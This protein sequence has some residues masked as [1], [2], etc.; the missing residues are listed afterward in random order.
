MLATGVIQASFHSL[1][2]VLVYKKKL[3]EDASDCIC[4][5]HRAMFRYE[6]RSF[7]N[8]QTPFCVNATQVPRHC[9]LT[10]RQVIQSLVTQS[11]DVLELTFRFVG[12]HFVTEVCS[13]EF[14]FVL[15]CHQ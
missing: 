14:S 4:Q 1:G 10:D 12:G 5:L 8:G 9:I 15:A 13:Q 2:H 3:P 7:E 11:D 6:W